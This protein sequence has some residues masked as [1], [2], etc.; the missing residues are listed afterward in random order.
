MVDKLFEDSTLQKEKQI[1]ILHQDTNVI[2]GP[3]WSHS[4]KME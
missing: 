4:V 1:P 2:T 3:Q